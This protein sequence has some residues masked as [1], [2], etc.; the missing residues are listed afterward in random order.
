MFSNNYKNIE[1]LSNTNLNIDLGAIKNLSNIAT[2]L[3]TPSGTLTNPGSLNITKDLTVGNDTQGS[4]NFLP[5]GSI[6]A[7]YGDQIPPGWRICDGNNG[8]PDLRGRFI[9]GSGQGNGLTNR[10]YNTSGGS[11]THTLTINEMPSHNHNIINNVEFQEY[12]P[13]R[14]RSQSGDRSGWYGGENIHNLRNMTLSNTGN[15][16]P[17]NNMPPFY[18]LKWWHI[19]RII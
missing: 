12:H 3:M 13:T 5:R 19:M 15:G 18:V 7:F 4:L 10:Q 8:T 14:F 6:I 16:Q 17:H 11:E 1:K 2:S 9:L